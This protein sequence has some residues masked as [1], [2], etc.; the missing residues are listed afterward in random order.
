MF[1]SVELKFLLQTHL[2]KQKAKVD[3]WSFGDGW[4]PPVRIL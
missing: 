4:N 1:R 2:P 3:D